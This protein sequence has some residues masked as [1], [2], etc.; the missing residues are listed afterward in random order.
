M[1]K[2]ILMSSR[3]DA[4]EVYT[5]AVIAKLKT[6]AALLHDGFITG[7]DLDKRRGVLSQ[8]E[9]IFATWGMPALTEDQIAEYLPNLKC[10]FYAASSV[11]SFAMPFLNRGV[12]IFNAWDSMSK[13]VA[14]FCV[15]AI[16]LAN[17]GFF[18]LFNRTKRTQEDYW[19]QS[20]HCKGNVGRCVGLVGLGRIG[21]YTAQ[22]LKAF[23]LKV[24]TYTIG[25]AAEETAAYGAELVDIEFL[26]R[27][28]DVIS[29]HLADNAG[30]KN[31]FDYRLLSLMKDD[32]VFLN[33]GLRGQVDEPALIR[34]LM[35]K[36]DRCAVLDN[37]W[38]VESEEKNPIYDLPNVFVPPTLAGNL[39]NEKQELANE[40]VE[41]F[42]KYINGEKIETE[43]LPDMLKYMA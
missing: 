32:A 28:C 43:M 11:H 20:H 18:R 37:M 29:N 24:Y 42:F 38:P 34:A 14:E 17:K 7:A 33:T 12:R 15:S 40:V 39:G 19:S 16:V 41:T 1:Y 27:E 6:K 21:K 8:A 35:D 2:S 25:M 5:P 23:D 4:V 36:P 31:F 30:T 10:I 3:P 22:L 13:P 9:F 26:M